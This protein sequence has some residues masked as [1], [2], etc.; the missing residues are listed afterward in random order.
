[1]GAERVQDED[2]DVV[3]VESDSVVDDATSIMFIKCRNKS[4][5][6]THGWLKCPLYM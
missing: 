6:T 5:G 1:M 3:G 4:P 2:G